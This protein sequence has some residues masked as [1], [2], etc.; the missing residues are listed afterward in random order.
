MLLTA[1]AECI[2]HLLSQG[3][4]HFRNVCCVSTSLFAIRFSNAIRILMTVSED[5][6]ENKWAIFLF[7]PLVTNYIY[8]LH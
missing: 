8:W 5:D 3:K 6:L 2:G 1:V 4:C 7:S